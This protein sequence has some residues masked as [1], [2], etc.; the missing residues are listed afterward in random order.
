[1]RRLRSADSTT[2]EGNEQTETLKAEAPQSTPEVTPIKI[3]QFWEY[4]EPLDPS[5]VVITPS[6][7][8]VLDVL[9]SIPLHSNPS[10]ASGADA[11][12]S[13]VVMQYLD[14]VY[15]S[16]SQQAVLAAMNREEQV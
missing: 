11:S 2:F 14:A 8:T 16:V 10:A 3:E 12:Q 4:N 7:D 15:K 5:L 1:M 9:G 6:S 13:K